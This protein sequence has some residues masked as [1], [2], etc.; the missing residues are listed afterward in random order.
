MGP[1]RHQ[2]PWGA[3]SRSPTE[4][5]TQEP[6]AL[7]PLVRPPISLGQTI[8]TQTFFPANTEFFWR[9]I[10]A[11]K[12]VW[13]DEKKFVWVILHHEFNTNPTSTQTFFRARNTHTNFFARPKSSRPCLVRSLG[14]PGVG[15]TFLASRRS[16]GSRNIR[17]QN[18]SFKRACLRHLDACH[19][20]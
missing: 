17:R 7:G 6:W 11:K 19:A 18:R 12:F 13:V 4:R 16:F 9:R 3:K 15:V 8:P 2:R 20:W 10:G 1:T 5:R 14:T